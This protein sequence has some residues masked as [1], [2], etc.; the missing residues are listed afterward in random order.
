MIGKSLR[1]FIAQ[2]TDRRADTQIW[3]RLPQS[4]NRRQ[5]LLEFN[6]FRLQIT[7]AACHDTIH[8]HAFV[9]DSFRRFYNLIHI[10]QLIRLDVR[11]IMSGLCTEF[12]I[13]RANA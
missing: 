11:L 6:I 7:I 4:V 1:C 3:K 5:Y 8:A 13:L 10:Q 2:D 12:A 9:I